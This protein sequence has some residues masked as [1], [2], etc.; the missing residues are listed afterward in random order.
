MK[1][2]LVFLAVFSIAFAVTATERTVRFSVSGWTCGSC[3]AASRI[4]LKKLDGV[5]EV[6]TNAAKKEAVVRYDETQVGPEKMV[7][8][9]AR[10]G[11]RA[12]LAPDRPAASAA[13]GESGEASFFEVPLGCAAVKNLGC[14]SLATPILDELEDDPQVAQAWL[15]HEGT[16]LAVVWKGNGPAAAAD[17]RVRV[18]NAFQKSGLEVQPLAGSELES[19]SRSFS[20]R[21]GWYRG[22]D[23]D[24]LS[25][26]E[27]RILAARL[28]QPVEKELGPSKAAALKKEFQGAFEKCFIG[29]EP[30]DRADFAKIALKYV[31]QAGVDR[32]ELAWDECFDGDESEK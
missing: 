3:A 10:L 14:G 15:N 21:K 31:N 8:T 27:A 13:S 16:I 18:A 20:T 12:V 32:M 30:L 24:N 6:T 22:E 29:R 11:Y 1:R 28:I 26:E 7:A 2:S 17:R 25:R 19:T 9:L 4:A 5:E 23:V